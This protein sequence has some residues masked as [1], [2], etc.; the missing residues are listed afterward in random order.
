MGG[1]V[2]SIIKA[3]VSILTFSL[4][5]SHFIDSDGCLS[6][7]DSFDIVGDF[8]HEPINAARQE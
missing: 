7:C 4:A 8:C 6:F 5:W 3:K 2:A 1:K